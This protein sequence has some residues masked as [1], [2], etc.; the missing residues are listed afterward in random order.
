MN[1]EKKPCSCKDAEIKRLQTL[2]I[3]LICAV[4]IVVVSFLAYLYYTAPV[5]EVVEEVVYEVHVDQQSTGG[6]NAYVAGD[7]E[8][9]A[10]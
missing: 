8:G 6:D 1:E 3:A 4:V 7:Y 5:E 2:C 9:G 10:E